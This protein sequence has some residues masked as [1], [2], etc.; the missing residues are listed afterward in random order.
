MNNRIRYNLDEVQ[1]NTFYQMPKFLFT[2]EFDKMSNDARVLYSL[3]K[4]RQEISIKNQWVNENNE[5]YL[6]CS[7]ENMGDM[8][9]LSKPT[10]IKAMNDLKKHNLIQEERLG[11]GKA[12]RIFLLSVNTIF[13]YKKPIET[14][15][16]TEKSNSFTSRDKE[17]LPQKVKD[18][19]PN[20]NDISNIKISDT[21]S[22]S[23]QSQ[24][25]PKTDLTMTFDNDTQPQL[26]YENMKKGPQNVSAN[27]SNRFKIPLENNQ[28]KDDYTTYKEI[29]QENIEYSYFLQNRTTNID[30]IDELVNC[31]LDVICTKGDTVKINGEE[32]NRNMVKSVYL[33][34][35][36]MDIEHVLDRYKDQY[37]KITHHHNYLK[38]ML[39]TIKQESSHFYTNL[40]NKDMAEGMPYK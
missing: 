30:M 7:R 3:L 1:R 27:Q 21:E 5:V 15:E 38:T 20:N 6:I 40:V 17:F 23:S 9:K 24:T 26:E 36:S 13:E 25:E 39:Y 32:K 34:I 14:L 22:K 28:F 31:M 10:V 29:I 16:N 8:L 2:E 4:D 19:Y 11:Q 33:K 12:N 35:N 37:H 18:F